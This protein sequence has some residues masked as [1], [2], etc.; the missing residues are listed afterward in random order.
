MRVVFV[1][2]IIA[3]IQFG[4]K[5]KPGGQINTAKKVVYSFVSDENGCGYLSKMES[6]PYYLFDADKQA[7]EAVKSIMQMTGLPANFEIKAADVENAVAVIEKDISPP[8]RFIFYSQTF[9]ENLQQKTGTPYGPLSV[10]A[11]EIGHHLAG[12][13][14]GR[15]GSRPLLEL[16]ADRFSGYILRKL[17]SSL[18]EAQ[19]AINTIAPANGT[20]TH[21]GK[22]ARLAA[23]ANGWK[24]ANEQFA[25]SIARPQQQASMSFTT[26]HTI[27]AAPKWAIALRNKALSA[28]ELL[29]VNSKDLNTRQMLDGETLIGVLKPGSPVHLVRQKDT[30]YEIDCMINGQVKR[31]FIAA[32]VYGK[33]TLIKQ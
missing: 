20:S 31:G 18:A 25:G 4:C 28:N 11:H 6:R 1:L 26:D 23:I 8:K 10:L 19:V 15:D 17:G 12:H 16:E 13:T 5:H 21:P 30:F 14:L 3:A 33:P 32:R 27:S 24:D 7:Q 29:M 2:T 22:G 9:F